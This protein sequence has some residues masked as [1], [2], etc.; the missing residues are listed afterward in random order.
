MFPDGRTLPPAHPVA[1]APR[2]HRRRLS[3]AA[4]AQAPGSSA[5]TVPHG[6]PAPRSATPPVTDSAQCGPCVPRDHR[7]D[8]FR[9]AGLSLS[10]LTGRVALSADLWGF[11]PA[12]T[13]QNDPLALTT[14]TK[15]FGWPQRAAWPDPDSALAIPPAL[16]HPCGPRCP[17]L[18]PLRALPPGA[19][20]C[21]QQ[22]C[23]APG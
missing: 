5:S 22:P 12:P 21:P 4:S 10:P 14:V 6:E 3:Q 20:R 15:T 18:A 7:L 1:P 11:Y 19:S 23:A 8:R 9:A 13:P 16:G 17:V 2:G